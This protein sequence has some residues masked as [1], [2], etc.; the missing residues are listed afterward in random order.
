MALWGA[1]YHLHVSMK[2]H[3][4]GAVLHV[5]RT[6]WHGGRPTVSASVA[7]VALG[8][9]TINAGTPLEQAVACCEA[10]LAALLVELHQG[11]ADA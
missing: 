10:A 1:S 11:E 4:R 2:S 7:S 8:E 5:N 9:L 3:G 6:R